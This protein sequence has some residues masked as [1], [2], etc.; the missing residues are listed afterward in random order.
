[1]TA[2]TSLPQGYDTSNQLWVMHKPLAPMRL[3]T[4]IVQLTAQARPL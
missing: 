4:A 2:D 3:R 1:M